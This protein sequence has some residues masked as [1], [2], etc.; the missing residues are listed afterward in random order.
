M[1]DF[2]GIC[3]SYGARDIFKDVSFRINKGDRV[4][5]VGPNGAGKTTLFK[6]LL[7]ELSADKGEIL[8]PKKTRIGVIRQQL[9]F[10]RED[11]TLL[12][13]TSAATGELAQT[14]K[15][16][17]ELEKELQNTSDETA[18]NKLLMR[19]GEKQSTFEAQGG[20]EMRHRAEAALSGLGFKVETFS[21]TMKQFSGGWQMRACMAKTLLSDPE[22]LLLDE[23]S[24]YLDTPAVE[25]LRKQLKN[26][27]GTILL[28]SH[29]R[30]L[31]NSITTTTLEINNG[32]AT[33]YNGSYSK[34][35]V[36]REERTRVAEAA[37]DN[38]DRKKEQ[39]ERNINRFRAKATKAAQVRSWIKMLDKL[40][41]TDVP[42]S[43]HFQGEI[44]IP[45]PP[46]CGAETFRLEDVTF[47]YDGKRN[48]LENI[49]LSINRGDKIGIV[50]YNGMGKSTLLK[51]IAGVN[52]PTSGRCILGHQVITGYQAQEFGELLPG[53]KTPIEIV[54]EASGGKAESKRV[55]EILGAFGFSGE[56]AE[57]MCEVLSGGEKIRLCFARIF[58]NPPNLLILDEPTTHLDIAA[59]EALEKAVKSYT[60]TVC[61]V[62]HDIEFIRAT[63]ETI[64]EMRTPSVRIHY[65]NYD[66]YRERIA[67]EEAAA[68][69]SI[70]ENKADS[71]VSSASDSK[72]RRRERAQ[73]RQ[74]LSKEKRKLE[75]NVAELEEKITEAEAEKEEII[76]LLAAPSPEKNFSDLRKKLWD[77]EE[78]IE[79]TT[80]AWEKSAS[81]LEELMVKY[82]EIH[83]D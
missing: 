36:E 35:I 73:K 3:K 79:K 39:L 4:G 23:P 13:F 63:A 21:H 47:S 12:E 76:N 80:L 68:N 30:F 20:Y 1:I 55:R 15:D 45:D 5:I 64:I 58:V 71:K 29:D 74:E 41:D 54:K 6:M 2:I 83:E 14:E 32:Y 77:L 49:S 17:A 59:R 60:G 40:E 7:G 72:E 44:R 65:G 56:A 52:Q 51:L 70:A 16:I 67:A 18:R 27:P 33:T 10:F 69:A 46:H 42:D 62:S 61:I 75:K 9:D 34:Y 25:W 48:I 82:N 57:K 50:G 24:N 66:Y 81:Q 37:Q 53:N 38:I 22:I 8:I 28:I 19:L 43:L 26:F 78:F 11:E 31:L